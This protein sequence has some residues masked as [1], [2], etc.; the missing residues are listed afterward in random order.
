MR[1]RSYR[2]RLALL[3]AVPAAL[4]LAAFGTIAWW[5]TYQSISARLD[6][7]IRSSSSI[8]R[9]RISFRAFGS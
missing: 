9:T 3:A 5:M 6:S 1:L 4:A 8:N 7:E 2:T